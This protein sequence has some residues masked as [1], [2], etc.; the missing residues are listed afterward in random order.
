MG[1]DTNQ[2]VRFW[3]FP[4]VSPI[5]ARVSAAVV[6]LLGVVVTMRLTGIQ[7]TAHHEAEPVLAPAPASVGVSEFPPASAPLP[8]SELPP[9]GA[10][11][12]T[13]PTPAPPVAAKPR[14]DVTVP[15]SKPKPAAAEPPESQRRPAR[16]P[17][18]QLWAVPDSDDQPH[19][20]GPT[21]P[22]APLSPTDDSPGDAPADDAPEFAAG[23]QRMP[24]R[25]QV[26]SRE[27]MQR[28][29]GRSICA[30]WGIPP[31]TCD[32]AIQRWQRSGR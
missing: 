25:Q 26:R 18:T 24:A 3:D 28:Q 19:A 10:A 32:E 16:H 15:T 4:T 2:T 7:T 29:L 6:L 30:R 17:E 13:T 1:E 20:E 11:P 22:T 27:E 9:P 8:Q 12:V 31:D 21:G 23:P 5:V 14:P